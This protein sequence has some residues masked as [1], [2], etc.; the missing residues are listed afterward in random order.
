VQNIRPAQVETHIL[1]FYT[2]LMSKF[3]A[4]RALIP[5][6]NLVEVRFEDLEKIPL[7]EL[8]KVY[9]GLGLPGYAGAEPAFRACLASTANYRKNSYEL[10]D[11]VITQ[12]NQHWQFA[13]DEWGYQCL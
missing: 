1:H 8:C 4:D 12:V 3:L 2:Q 10:T 9:E 6:G 11:A 13:S 5:A 7:A